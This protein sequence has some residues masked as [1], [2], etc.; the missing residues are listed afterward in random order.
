LRRLI[1]LDSGVIGLLLSPRP[2]PE[3]HA[4]ERWLDRVEAARISIQIPLIC[5]YEVRREWE[6]LILRDRSVDPVRAASS[7]DSLARLGRF[8]ERTGLSPIN[9]KTI[10][11]ASQL[12]GEARQRGLPTASDEALDADVILAATARQ[13]ARGGRDVWVI[14][15]NLFHLSRFVPTC[16]WDEYPIV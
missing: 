14:S 2:F 1:L 7:L 12:W 8:V 4:C 9:A 13:A 10:V 5:Y 16:R 15:T 6:R 3:V 11:R